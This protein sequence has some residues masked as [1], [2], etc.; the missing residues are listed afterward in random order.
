[1]ILYLQIC[2]FW[3]EHLDGPGYM[4]TISDHVQ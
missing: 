2:F 3:G 4:S 1:M